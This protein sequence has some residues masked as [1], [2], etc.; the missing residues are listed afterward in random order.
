MAACRPVFKLNLYEKL[1]ASTI[2]FVD[3]SLWDKA[4]C[5]ASRITINVNYCIEN[6]TVKMKFIQGNLTKT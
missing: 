3:L 6:S 4:Y 1:R 2:D 5:Y